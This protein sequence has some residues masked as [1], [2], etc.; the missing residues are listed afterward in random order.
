MV[1]TGHDHG[2]MDMGESESK[3]GQE[4]QP[5]VELSKPLSIGKQA[6]DALQPLYATYLKWKDALT[7]DDFAEAQKIATNMK[8]ALDKINM[9]LFKGDAHNAW[10]DYQGKLSSSLEYNTPQN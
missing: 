3:E 1:S 8:S 5:K 9:N 7:N 10:M 2:G 4:V 6:K